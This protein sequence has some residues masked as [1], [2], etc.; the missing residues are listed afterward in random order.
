MTIQE[1]SNTFDTLLN[2][3]RDIKDFGKTQSAYSLE[4]N[5]YEKSVLLTQAQDL[6]VKS[7]FDGTLNPQGQG[8]DETAR[9][10][11]D[12]SDLVT[13]TEPVTSLADVVK[14]DDRGSIYTMPSNI[15]FMLNEKIIDSAHKTYVVVPLHYREYDRQMSKAYAQPLK[16]QCWRLFQ[17]AIGVDLIS[18]IIPIYGITI[19][20]YRIRYVRRPVPIILVNLADGEY[21]NTLD[22]DGVSSVSQCELN[23]IVHMDI[24]NKAVE[25]AL[26]RVGIGAPAKNEK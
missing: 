5:E 14:F 21:N 19:S 20:K 2:S 24:L 23:P 18:Q 4:L 17:S 26:N 8:F 3:Y 11:I 7:Y 9:R 25:L 15:L 13:V 16:K 10:Q 12:F 6:I 1:F 22:I